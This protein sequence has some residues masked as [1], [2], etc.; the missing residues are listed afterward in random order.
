LVFQDVPF[1]EER[2]KMSQTR[3]L[4]KVHQPQQSCF[5]WHFEHQST[6]SYLL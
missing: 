6:P 5:V 4:Y 2:W 3:K 1:K